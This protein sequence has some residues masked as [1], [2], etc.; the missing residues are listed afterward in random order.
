[1]NKD[2]LRVEYGKVEGLFNKMAKAKGYGQMSAIGSRSGGSARRVT[3]LLIRAVHLRSDGP[4]QIRVRG[5][6]GARR[7]NISHSGAAWE[8]TGLRRFGVSRAGLGWGLAVEHARGTR[9]PLE[10]VARGCRVHSMVRGD[11]DGSGQRVSP[12]C[13]RSGG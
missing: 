13:A 7:G 3:R 2:G 4:D 12:A 8:L 9:N 10:V 1:M 11:E 5:G 6:G